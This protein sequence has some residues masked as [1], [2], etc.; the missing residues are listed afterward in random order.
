MVSISRNIVDMV[1]TEY[2]I[3]KL[4]D[5][6]VRQRMENLIAVAHPDFRSELRRQAEKLLLL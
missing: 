5:R 1:V 4:R 3:A 2:G 6:T